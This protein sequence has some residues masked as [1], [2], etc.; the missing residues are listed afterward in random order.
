MLF[1]HGALVGFLFSSSIHIVSVYSTPE[2]ALLAGN[3]FAYAVS[4]K[5]KFILELKEK[6]LVASDVY[7]FVFKSDHKLKFKHGQYLEWTL[8]HDGQD[9]RGIRRY[10]SIASSPPGLFNFLGLFIFIY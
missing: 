4:P 6:I 7:D 5:H 8:G 2:L 10:F 1:P 9:A 3:I